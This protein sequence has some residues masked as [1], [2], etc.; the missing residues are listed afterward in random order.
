MYS[1]YYREKRVN[2][3][4]WFDFFQ[5]VASGIRVPELVYSLFESNLWSLN[6]LQLI[7]LVIK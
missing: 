3:L 5:P 7:D 6:G 2:E 4:D 1:K